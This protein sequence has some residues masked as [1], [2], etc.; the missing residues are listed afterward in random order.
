MDFSVLLSVYIGESRK[1]IDLALE[2]VFKQTLMP[3]QIVLVKDGPLTL[4]LEE[5]IKKYEI[6]YPN[7]FDVVGLDI[8]QGLGKALNIGLK[9]CKF[10]IIAR[11]DTDDICYLNRFEEQ[12]QFMN[13]NRDISVVGCVVQ[14]FNKEPGDLR[15]FRKLPLTHKD[16]VKFSKYRNPLSHPSVMFKKKDVLAV[17]SYID[18]PLFEDYYLWTRLIKNGF[19]IANM[20]NVL[21]HFRIGNDM[22]GR[23]SGFSYFKKELFFLK[24]L[25]NLK[26]L[27]KAEYIK[28][29]VLKAPLR[30]LPK[31]LL[32]LIYKKLLR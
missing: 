31:S 14:E 3:N 7:I 20:E 24:T 25:K 13:S 21:L 15:Q 4:E 5:V 29:I 22:V 11:M 32:E 8:N 6:L 9:Y 18:M 30:L 28:S 10:D 19:K 2:S 1:N 27:N 23:R 26:V 12:I 16:L 17:G